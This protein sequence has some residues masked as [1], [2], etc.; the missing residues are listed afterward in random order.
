MPHRDVLNYCKTQAGPSGLA[1]TASIYTV[2]AFGQSRY[3]LCGDT[4]AAVLNREHG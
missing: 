4:D 3:M 1:R 2:E